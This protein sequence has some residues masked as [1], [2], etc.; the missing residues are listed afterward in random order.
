M[1][2]FEI[3]VVFVLVLTFGY[4]LVRLFPDPPSPLRSGRNFLS[5]NLWANS[6][7]SGAGTILL[8]PVVGYF[9]GVAAG[10]LLLVAG[11]VLVGVSGALLRD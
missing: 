5:N 1:Q 8:A 7:W 3:A 2:I 10:A 6:W 4:A 9:E 11:A